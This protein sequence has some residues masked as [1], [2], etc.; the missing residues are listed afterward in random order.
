MISFT[1]TIKKFSSQGEKTGWT[2][3]LIPA[4]LVQ[5]LN[6]GMKKTFRVKG[7]LDNLD[8]TLLSLLPMGGGDF[9]MT[10]NMGMRKV[11]RKQKG[12]E[13]FV[14]ME[15]DHAVIKPPP[16]LMD[17]LSDEP[18]ALAHFYSLSTSQQNYFS[19]WIRSAKTEPTVVKRI[20]AVIQALD[21]GWDFGQMLRSKKADNEI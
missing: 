10:I 18:K 5:Q 8:F 2:Y 16:L 17:C 19:N 21:K 9:I 1:T 12:A 6:P 11:I 20:T 3:I 14:R 13:V 4:E 7:R 15:V